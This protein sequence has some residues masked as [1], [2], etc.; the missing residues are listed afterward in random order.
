MQNIEKLST[1]EYQ[2]NTRQLN[3]IEGVPSVLR[4]KHHIDDIP[5]FGILRYWK[6]FLFKIG[7]YNLRSCLTIIK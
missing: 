4:R 6:F 7:A 5:V 2:Q 1:E 3:A